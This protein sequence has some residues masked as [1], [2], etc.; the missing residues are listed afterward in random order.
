MLK[1]SAYAL[2]LGAGATEAFAPSLGAGLPALRSAKCNSNSRLALRMQDDNVEYKPVIP[3]L[4]NPLA[5]DYAN[6]PT[7]FERQGL[8]SKTEKSDKPMVGSAGALEEFG[9]LTRREAYGAG[10]AVTVGILAVGWAFTR[11][12]GYDR[13]DTTRDAGK[14]ELNKE[15]LGSA[16]VKTNLAA[17]QASRDKLAELYA[18]FQADN[19]ALLSEGVKSSF[20]VVKL[21]DEFNKLTFAVFDEDTQIKTDRIVRNSIQSLV[22]LEQAVKLK[23]GVARSP[24]RVAAT[25]KWFRQALSEF[26]SFLAYFK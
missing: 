24:K 26:D 5:P 16:E 21:R 1:Y 13:K 15:A 4:E 18:K 9:G 11:N 6:E 23:D 20:N 12:P 8:V 2:L 19:N 14:V 10:G 22:E 3:T 25:D 17:V 7:Q